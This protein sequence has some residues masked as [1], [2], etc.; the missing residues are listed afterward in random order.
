MVM[1]CPGK[2]RLGSAICGF[3]ALRAARVTPNLA[4]MALNVSPERTIY[5]AIIAPCSTERLPCPLALE[6]LVSGI[7]ALSSQCDVD[8]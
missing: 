2:M 4:A 5:L 3:A 1:T 6:R 8:F 7:A